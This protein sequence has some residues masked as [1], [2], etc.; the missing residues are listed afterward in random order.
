MCGL[1]G[2][3]G[4]GADGQIISKAAYLAST[5]GPHGW[6]V[7]WSRHGGNRVLKRIGSM[8]D[9]SA[10]LEGAEVVVGHCRLATFGSYSDQ[11]QLQ[12]FVLG[13]VVTAIN[14]NIYNYKETGYPVRFGNDAEVLPY[15]VRDYGAGNFKQA[16]DIRN[17]AMLAY[18]GK[19]LWAKNNRLPLLRLEHS[20]GVYYCSR[21]IKT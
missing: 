2:Y 16:A 9:L 7:F 14:G 10:K 21:E 1:F 13:E 18:D 15:L 5:R 12:P 4:S 20:T 8:V 19:K 17:Y 6:G 3:I 11:D